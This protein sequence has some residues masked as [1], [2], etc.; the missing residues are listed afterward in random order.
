M[1]RTRVK[2]CGITRLADAEAAIRAG[3]DALGFVFYEPSPRY[4][5]P[6]RAAEIIAQLPPLVS[7]VG[8]FV[9]E[10]S[11]KVRDIVQ[12]S[13]I[14]M[15]QFHGDES[16]EFCDSFDRPWFKALRVRADMDIPLQCRRYHKARGIL[17]DAYRPGVPGG[18]GESF[19]W[20]LIPKELPKPL[21][22]AGG[23][24]PA[25]VRKAI[26]QVQPYA[27]D[28]SGGVEADKGIKDSQKIEVF[29]QEVVRANHY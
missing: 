4:I 28:I 7:T 22:L 23:L 8:L 18:T 21:I 24:T 17:L 29:M 9:D 12:Q 10:S 11:E 16:P 20:S 19:D 3:A 13:R 27:V 5:E 6:S 25:N 15:L 2:I 1:I 26:R 14:D